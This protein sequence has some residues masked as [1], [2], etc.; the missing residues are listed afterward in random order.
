MTDTLQKGMEKAVPGSG[1]L[2]SNLDDWFYNDVAKLRRIPQVRNALGE[3]P[4]PQN[5]VQYLLTKPNNEKIQIFNAL[6]DKGKDALKEAFFSSAFRRGNS[7][8]EFNPNT[9]AKFLEDNRDTIDVL[10]PEESTAMANLAKVMRHAAGEG[11]SQ[12]A[13]LWNAIR[14]FPF[15]YRSVIQNVRRSNAMY[16]LQNASPDLRP[17]SPEMERFYRSFL[18]NL[19]VAGPDR[20]SEGIQGTQEQMEETEALPLDL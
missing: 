13:S 14:G 18:R 16:F 11:R 12:D 15:I 5:L 9:Y 3:N 17:G 4:M 20:V 1:Q 6:S 2:L 8:R 19:A 10:M 7:G